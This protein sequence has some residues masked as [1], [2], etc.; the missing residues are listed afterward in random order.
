MASLSTSLSTSASSH[1]SYPSTWFNVAAGRRVALAAAAVLL[2]SVSG[3]S[4]TGRTLAEPDKASINSETS[5]APSSENTADP[6]QGTPMVVVTTESM[7]ETEAIPYSSRTNSGPGMD[8]GSSRTTEGKK[9]LLTRTV[10]VVKHGGIEVSRSTVSEVVTTAPVD[11]ITYQG[12]R[13]PAAPQK[14]TAPQKEDKSAASCDPNY[15]DAC[16]PIA[17]DVDCKGGTGD[18]PMYLEGQARVI[19]KDVYGLDKDKDGIAC[20]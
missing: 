13:E 1:K 9:G 3:C 4:A 7:T 18:G 17:K 10:E 20:N 12:T 16:V 2:I 5:P 8:R 15:A 14:E 19:G 11:K 6:M